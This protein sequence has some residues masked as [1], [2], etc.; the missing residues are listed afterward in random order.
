M[1]EAWEKALTRELYDAFPS[2]QRPLLPAERA[3]APRPYLSAES[4]VFVHGT[5]LAFLVPFRED[6]SGR[7]TP[8]LFRLLRHLHTEF[9]PHLPAGYEAT[10]LV[11]EQSAYGTFNKGKLLNAGARWCQRFLRSPV[12]LVLQDVDMLPGAELMPFYCHHRRGES[13]HPGWINRKYDYEDFF[14]SVC[15]AT[16]EDYVSAGGCPNEFWGW[17]KEDDC[18]YWRLR[19]CGRCEILRPSAMDGLEHLDDPKLWINGKGVEHNP[20]R[21]L[22][23]EHMLAARDT[24]F[25]PP[26]FRVL[27]RIRDGSTQHL[28][29]EL[30]KQSSASEGCTR[31]G[32]GP[33]YQP[34]V[35]RWLC[36]SVCVHFEVVS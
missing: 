29:V 24:L 4:A 15:T 18:L 30:R 11:L 17:G 20:L 35:L 12:L 5:Q 33:L 7:R 34:G 25:D 27:S 31:R 19:F 26:D 1:A 14:G 10:V 23:P 28:L 21:E 8:Q 9:L 36:G 16:L 3:L 2:G 13:V 6:F 32:V 22:E